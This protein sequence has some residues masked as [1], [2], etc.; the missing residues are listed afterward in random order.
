MTTGKRTGRPPK[1][2]GHFGRLMAKHGH[3]VTSLHRALRAQ[4]FVMNDRVVRAAAMGNVDGVRSALL[5]RVKAF[6]VLASAIGGDVTPQAIALAMEL[7]RIEA[8][9]QLCLGCGGR[10]RA[11]DG[12]HESCECTWRGAFRAVEARVWE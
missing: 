10:M 1:K 11:V 6:G 9:G 3:T 4:G 7:D 5:D 8:G 2:R 12:S